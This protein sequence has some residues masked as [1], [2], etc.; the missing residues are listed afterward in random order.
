MKKVN[1]GD[2]LGTLDNDYYDKIEREFASQ[3]SKN[4][5]DT[6]LNTNIER[7]GG[8]VFY[9]MFKIV[10]QNFDEH[11]TKCF[12]EI[13]KVKIKELMKNNSGQIKVTKL[14]KKSFITQFTTQQYEVAKKA[15]ITP[16][17]LS[18]VLKNTLSDFYAFEVI[19]LAITNDMKPKVA[20]EQLYYIPLTDSDILK[21]A[22]TSKKN[23]PTG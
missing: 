15:G 6:A 7:L 17:R 12:D 19:S 16:S 21:K 23:K 18:K 10:S 4:A 3:L 20:F 13:I 5:I 8:K 1:F 22:K 11:C 2:L 14:D 9:Y